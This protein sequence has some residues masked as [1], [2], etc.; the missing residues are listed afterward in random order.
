MDRH[1]QFWTGNVGYS[2]ANSGRTFYIATDIA[3]QYAY[4]TCLFTF[5]HLAGRLA[6]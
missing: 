1:G 5:C 2:F 3:M 6:V 4:F